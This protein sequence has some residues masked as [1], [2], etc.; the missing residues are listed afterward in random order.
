MASVQLRCNEIHSQVRQFVDAIRITPHAIHSAYTNVLHFNHYTYVLHS[1]GI[2]L[3]STIICICRWLHL[4]R[5]NKV[6]VVAKYYS[7]TFKHANHM[8]SL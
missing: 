4:S 1:I 3:K 7:I 6:T 2:E 8:V 5:V